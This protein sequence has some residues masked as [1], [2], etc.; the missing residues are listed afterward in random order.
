MVLR[1]CGQ[2][3]NF[4]TPISV[5]P[6]NSSVNTANHLSLSVEDIASLKEF[7]TSWNICMSTSFIFPCEGPGCDCLCSCAFVGRNEY[8]GVGGCN[9]AVS[10]SGIG[11]LELLGTQGGAIGG[12]RCLVLWDLFNV[13][14]DAG[15][16]GLGG[17]VGGW[18]RLAKSSPDESDS[19]SDSGIWRSLIHAR[20]N[21]V[22][23]DSFAGN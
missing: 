19:L 17:L 23:F 12:L 13:D 7:G 14:P 6:S 10:M 18:A 1:L 16:P 3:T 11:V 20:T 21:F 4:Q 15:R 9:G 22:A 2:S 5:R 8:R